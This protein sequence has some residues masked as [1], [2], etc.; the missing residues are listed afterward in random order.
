MRYL[1]HLYVYTKRLKAYVLLIPI[2]TTVTL[3]EHVYIYPNTYA[4]LHY[5]HNLIVLK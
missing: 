2:Y 1:C 4:V 5:F 3:D